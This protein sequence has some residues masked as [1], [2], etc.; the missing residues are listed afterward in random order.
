MPQLQKRFDVQPRDFV[1]AG[2]ASLQVQRMLRNI[3]FE[4]QIIRRASVCA[5]EAEMNIVMYGG[6]GE[7][8]LTVNPDEIILQ[9]N[10]DGPGIENIGAALQEGFS[11]A[12]AEYREMGFGAGMGLPNIKKNADFLD[13]RSGRHQGTNLRIVFHCT[14]ESR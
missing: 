2:E 7:I 5:Y 3:G 4:E 12:P 13:I 8:V 14:G 11:T 9:V 1:R 10:D 6:K